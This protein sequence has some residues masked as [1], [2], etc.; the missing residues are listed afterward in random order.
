[1]SD[2]MRMFAG[3]DEAEQLAKRQAL[4]RTVSEIEQEFTRDGEELTIVFV[5]GTS[6]VLR[7]AAEINAGWVEGTGE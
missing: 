2:S 3:G 4:G 5:D 1:M 7:S 6:L